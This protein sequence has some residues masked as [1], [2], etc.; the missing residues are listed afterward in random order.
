M[1]LPVHSRKGSLQR[2]GQNNGLSDDG[3]SEGLSEGLSSGEQG[4]V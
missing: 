1:K 4:Y 2:H 3:K